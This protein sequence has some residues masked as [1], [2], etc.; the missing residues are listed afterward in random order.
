MIPRYLVRLGGGR[1]PR[2]AAAYA[3]FAMSQKE[4]VTPRGGVPV[5][6]LSANT[7]VTTAQP[8]KGTSGEKSL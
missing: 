6:E 8:I 2:A 3:G 4:K 5:V 7:E 1:A